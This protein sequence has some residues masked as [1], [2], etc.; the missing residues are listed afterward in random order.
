MPYAHRDDQGRIAALHR[1][2]QP[3]AR[4]WVDAA[5]PE[6][7]DFL[8]AQ[9]SSA[10]QG[11][12]ADDYDRLDAGF[13]RVLEDLIDALL[14]RGVIAITDLPL[15]A[16][17]KLGARKGRRTPTPLAALIL[18]GEAEPGEGPGPG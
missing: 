7:R 3:L 5:D 11:G 18:L 12:H 17:R 4:E 15:E 14:A 2:P 13:I 1:S 6:V 8:D 16:R 10:A 9:E